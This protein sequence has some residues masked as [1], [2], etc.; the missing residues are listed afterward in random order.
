MKRRISILFTTS[1]LIT[2]LLLSACTGPSNNLKDNTVNGKNTTEQTEQIESKDNVEK[3]QSKQ[4]LIKESKL[5]DDFYNHV[6]AKELNEKISKNGSEGK[7]RFSEATDKIDENVN[8]L[9]EEIAKE[10]EKH[11]EGSAERAIGLLYK[12]AFDHKG[13]EKAGLG[14]LKPYIDSIQS[15][16]SI[17]AYLKAIAKV[18]KELGNSSLFT[19]EAQPDPKD[20]TK[21]SLLFAQPYMMGKKEDLEQ[22]SMKKDMSDYIEKLIKADGTD[23]KDKKK[24]VEKVVNF[25]TD[26]AKAAHT[27]TDSN[28]IE[29]ILNYKTMDEIQ[30][31]IPNMN[32][33]EYFDE[34][35]LN[36]YYATVVENPKSLSVINK[37]LTKDNLEM[38]KKY[39][40]SAL[41]DDYGEYL[42]KDIR[43]AKAVFEQREEN[44]D[45][46]SL[47]AVKK[48]ADMEI[49]EIYAKKY[50]SPEKKEAVEKMIGDIVGAYKKN[51]EKLDW[52]SP[53]SKAEAIKKLENLDLKIGYPET[54]TSHLKDGTVKSGAE[55]GSLIDNAVAINKSKAAQE[56]TR[57]SSPVN[58]GEWGMSSHTLN[59]YYDPSTNGV[60]FPAAI[61]QSPFYDEKASYAQNLGSLGAVIAHEITHAFDDLGSHYDE[62]G[63]LRNWWSDTDRNAF[64]EKAQSFIKYFGNFEALPG[65]KVD[66]ELTLG[67]NIAD[68]GG[69]SVVTTL[70]GDDKEA[71]KEMY[72]SYAKSWASLSN[73]ED[74]IEQ[75]KSDE[76]APSKIR[77]NAVLSSTDKFYEAFD[78]KPGDGMYVKPEDRVHMY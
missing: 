63:N 19:F 10:P 50:F 23:S 32:L 56:L 73:D 65:H 27:K 4:K 62:K 51:I 61:L 71:L 74:I 35:G 7:D 64:K 48:L 15:A 12:S 69:I 22:E 31:E 36:G 26:L 9:V 46:N 40:I 70:L 20:S 55:G 59:A 72:I 54:Y 77:V 29:K 75:L 37:Y 17:P 34:A 28:N 52:M 1:A 14:P 6:N 49:G 43:N 3:T 16:D 13:N 25:Q 44:D 60:V 67:E 58:R 39:S 21:H 66:G 8:K 30:S 78:I 2:A 41:L 11:P 38:L 57:A 24:I 42:N 76:H 33:K 68:L 5:Q 47:T 18:K 53:E 45:E